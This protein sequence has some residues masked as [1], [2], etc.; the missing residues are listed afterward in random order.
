MS[1]GLAS[2]DAVSTTIVIFNNPAGC[3]GGCGVDEILDLVLNQ[4]D[5]AQLSILF[6]PG[7]V[8]NG[9]RATWGGHLQAGET[10]GEPWAGAGLTNPRG[11]HISFL[12]RTHGEIV[13]GE[14]A[15]QIHTIL[16]G[17]GVNFCGYIQMAVHEP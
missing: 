13:P 4:N 6:G 17:C 2:G 1:T 9:P 16:G 8:T 5:P 15:E 3:T 7:H 10:S 11:A 12:L 14:V